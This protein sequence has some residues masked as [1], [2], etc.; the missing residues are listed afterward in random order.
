VI[1]CDRRRLV[2]Y[3]YANGTCLN[4][5]LMQRWQWKGLGGPPTVDIALPVRLQETGHQGF[6]GNVERPLRG[7]FTV[8]HQLVLP[9][10]AINRGA[11]LVASSL[12]AHTTPQHRCICRPQRH[13][14]HHRRGAAAYAIFMAPRPHTLSKGL[15][16]DCS[17][18]S[19]T[20]SPDWGSPVQTS[21]LHIP[22]RNNIG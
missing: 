19:P 17:P 2:T 21:V 1:L 7:G 20:S 3:L 5:P 18:S 11:F 6:G 12:A 9:S 13:Y 15:A 14:L 8:V 16:V 4:G 22:V 10:S